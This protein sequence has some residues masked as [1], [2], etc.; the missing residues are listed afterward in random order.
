MKIDLLDEHIIKLLA[1]D[2]EQSTDSIAKK[3]KMH[4][5]TIRRRV[6]DLVRNKVIRLVAAVD[7]NKMGF[8]LAAVITFHADPH[9]LKSAVQSLANRR[10][11][12]WCSTTTG[13]FD[14][15]TLVRVA[16][17]DDLLELAETLLT[18][19]EGLINSE[20]FVC[21]N[22]GKGRYSLMYADAP[23]E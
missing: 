3:L 21:L 16:S 12:V 1:P 13:R 4:P 14:I 11:V 5:T 15:I 2:T 20:T 7:P 9:K 19:V 22:V 8:P 10:E 23:S 18:Q 6:Q 17:T